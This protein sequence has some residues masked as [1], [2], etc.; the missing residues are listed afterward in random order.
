MRSYL[1]PSLVL[2]LFFCIP[3]IAQNSVFTTTTIAPSAAT[4]SYDS[5]TPAMSSSSVASYFAAL[6]TSAPQQPNDD[7]SA[8]DVG[9]SAGAGDSDAG[10]S[11]SS[12]GTLEIS[13]NGLIALIVCVSFVVLFGSKS[14]VP[15]QFRNR[16]TIC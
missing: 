15:Q 14:T 13:K 6:A 12:S 4:T 10:A 5:L 3:A 16:R 11:G 7:P 1:C 8:G 2:T 9:S